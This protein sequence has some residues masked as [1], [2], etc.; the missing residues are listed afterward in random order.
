MNAKANPLRLN[1]LQL[2]PLL[3]TAKAPLISRQVSTRLKKEKVLLG[4]LSGLG[5]E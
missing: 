2:K 3:L 5:V 4:D 1:I